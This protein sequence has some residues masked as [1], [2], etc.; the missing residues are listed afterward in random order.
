MSLR[1]STLICLLCGLLTACAAEKKLLG[2]A[3]IDGTDDL[4]AAVDLDEDRAPGRVDS[5]PISTIAARSSS[6]VCGRIAATWN[7][8]GSSATWN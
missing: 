7:S 4:D 2:D 6:T 5:P 1:T 8:R 3:G